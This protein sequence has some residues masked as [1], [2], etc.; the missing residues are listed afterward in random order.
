MF[1]NK[2]IKLAVDISPKTKPNEIP[3]NTLE[4][5][6]AYISKQL[7]EK[8][9]EQFAQGQISEQSVYKLL[10]DKQI[11]IEKDFA[12]LESYRGAIVN[13]RKL[14]GELIR[15]EGS[16]LPTDAVVNSI[17]DKLLQR[18]GTVFIPQLVKLHRVDVRTVDAVTPLLEYK[19]P[20]EIT[21]IRNFIAIEVQKK[22]LEVKNWWNEIFTAAKLFNPSFTMKQ[23]IFIFQNTEEEIAQNDEIVLT[24]IQS[25]EIKAAI[26]SLETKVMMLNSKARIWNRILEIHPD[27]EN[28]E[29]WAALIPENL[30][31]QWN[32]S[33]IL[34]SFPEYDII[35]V[36]QDLRRR[37]VSTE[38]QIGT[39]RPS[40]LEKATK[41]EIFYYFYPDTDENGKKLETDQDRRIYA[42]SKLKECIENGYD[43]ERIFDVLGIKIKK[44]P[45]RQKRTREQIQQDQQ[46]EEQTVEEVSVSKRDANDSYGAKIRYYYKHL[47]KV[48]AASNVF[49]PSVPLNAF[50]KD[51]RDA[52]CP[53][54]AEILGRAFEKP[55]DKRYQEFDLKF[56]S[57]EEMNMCKVLREDYNLD[58][59]PFPVKIP[60]PVDNPTSTDRFE[61]DFLLPCDV[62]LGFEEEQIV[63]PVNEETGEVEVRIIRKPIIERRVMFIGEYF[64]IRLTMD[65]KIED[66]GRPWVR[67]SGTL[68]IYEYPKA[69]NGPARYICAPI[70]P[71]REYEFYKLKTEWKM[72]TTDIIAD[73]LGTRALSL[74]D[75]DLDYPSN[76]MKKLDAANIIYKSSECRENVGCKAMKM[77]E[78]TCTPTEE[79][80]KIT[81]YDLIKQNF[82]D[83]V[84]RC[85]KIIDC[86]IINVKLSEGLVQ[87]KTEFVTRDKNPEPGFYNNGFNRQSMW[88]H[89]QHFKEL[90]DREQFLSQQLAVKGDAQTRQQ[91]EGLRSQINNM[92]SSPLYEFKEHTDRVLNSG[93]IGRKIQD[94]E[95]LKKLV[96]SGKITPSF[97][98][99]RG[100]I[101]NVTPEMLSQ[102]DERGSGKE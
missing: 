36:P 82:D 8:I 80:R 25:Q 96:E 6:V 45:R 87:A 52:G 78:A 22:K 24:P 65:K 71:C 9:G 93:T 42:L 57:N 76:L 46:N 14:A 30:R 48:G 21:T 23:M 86:A 2:K 63:S 85:I 31:M 67:P 50:R 47:L 32:L 66:K 91:L 13:L 10:A 81:D 26:A 59:I 84:N 15:S 69:K 72:F 68:P 11:E 55:E 17:I 33:L 12:F 4:E 62:L 58:A 92:Y 51:L 60:C 37:K 75:T 77:I 35:D 5:K 99:L 79:L 53:G 49:D 1:N 70:G 89:Q 20:E 43:N 41:D 54:V 74:D 16:N 94:L 7:D 64:G 39:E 18:T 3:G 102:L 56:L 98:E 40:K 61:I 95:E 38:P 34:R 28:R 97:A 100:L 29:E 101:I 19:K 90:R 27:I 83:H 73:M 44:G 88:A